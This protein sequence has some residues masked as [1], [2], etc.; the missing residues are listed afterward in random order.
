[1]HDEDNEELAVVDLT[2]YTGSLTNDTWYD[3]S[4]PLEDFHVD[5]DATTTRGFTFISSAVATLHYDNI[6][7][8][9]VS[10]ATS[11]TTSI[12]YVHTDHLGGTNVV[13][14]DTGE[15][16]EVV[17]YYPYGEQR[18]SDTLGSVV[19]QLKFTGHE[20]DVDSDLTYAKARYYDQ[21]IGKWL[22]QDPTVLLTPTQFLDDPQQL[23]MY[24]YVRNNPTNLVDPTGQCV[25]VCLAINPATIS[26]VAYVWNVAAASLTTIA[27]AD[28]V[29]TNTI[30]ADVSTSEEQVSS[31]V[32]AGLFCS[33]ESVSS[34]KGDSTTNRRNRPCCSRSRDIRRD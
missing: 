24:A 3:V 33:C 13:T 2:T 21:E 6:R 8:V 30:H 27:V 1:M 5:A 11:A 18:I 16:V 28:A 23:N 22:G 10:E 34:S 25:P 9:S 15:A 20:Y 14:D 29:R 7:F 26:V 17:D 12:K 31:V 19:E 4:V 32:S